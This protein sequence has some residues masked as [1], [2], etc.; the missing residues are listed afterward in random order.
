[1]TEESRYEN[2]PD[3]PPAEVSEG[4]VAV[5]DAIEDVLGRR[6]HHGEVSLR[7]IVGAVLSERRRHL[8]ESR[9]EWGLRVACDLEECDPPHIDDGKVWQITKPPRGVDVDLSMNG[10]K[11]RIVTRRVESGE[12][13]VV[14]EVT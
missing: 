5:Y 2:P 11:T 13:T 10:H 4:V 9:V 8:T 6:K 14:E 3:V 7:M 1:M 12:W